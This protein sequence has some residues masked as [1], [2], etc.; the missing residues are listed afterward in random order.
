MNDNE[1]ICRPSTLLAKSVIYSIIIYSSGGMRV[2]L[3]GAELAVG[4]RYNGAGK[5]M[6]WNDDYVK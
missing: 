2:A 4:P 6:W 3:G 1:V 5:E